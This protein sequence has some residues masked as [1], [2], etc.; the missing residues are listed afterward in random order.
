MPNEARLDEVLTLG[1]LDHIR[2]LLDEIEINYTLEDK[3]LKMLWKTDH[4]GVDYDGDGIDDSDPLKIR[5]V[6]NNDESWVY[7]V[8]PFQN[9][10]QVSEEHRAKF[11]YDMLRESWKANG[12]KFAI[13]DDDDIIV[14]AE[15]NDTDLNAE[16]IRS[17][18]RNVVSACDRLWSIFPA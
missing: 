5:I 9:F 12:V 11:A 4:F 2:S 7:I 13:D 15:T 3:A 8:A 10:Q 1:V 17:L 18:V 16:E 6:T 14:I